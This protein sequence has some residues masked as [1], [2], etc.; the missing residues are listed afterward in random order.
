MLLDAVSRNWWVF[1]VRRIAA[2]VFGP[3]S[4]MLAW[5]LRGLRGQMTAR[6]A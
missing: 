6:S 5:Q 2:I 4:L 3:I 1:A